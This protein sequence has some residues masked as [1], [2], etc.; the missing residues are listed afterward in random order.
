MIATTIINSIRVKPLMAAMKRGLPELRR[1]C[2]I[3]VEKFRRATEFQWK[4][5]ALPLV[6]AQ[7]SIVPVAIERP[8]SGICVDWP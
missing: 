4:T 2:F 1:D 3:V 5:I 7:P 8:R 6:A